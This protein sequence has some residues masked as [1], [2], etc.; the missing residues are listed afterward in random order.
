MTSGPPAIS[1]DQGEMIGSHQGYNFSYFKTINFTV[2]PSSEDGLAPNCLSLPHST[3]SSL[4]L[5]G[6]KQH[7]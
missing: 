4:H 7:T 6:T 3:N 2:L 1:V 5:V